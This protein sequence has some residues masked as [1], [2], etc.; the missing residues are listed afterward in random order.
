MWLFPY[1]AYLDT[2]KSNISIAAS[3]WETVTG[4]RRY[5]D[6]VFLII[7]S[8]C[9]IINITVLN[10][11]AAS[12]IRKSFFLLGTFITLTSVTSLSVIGSP[13][14]YHRYMLRDEI[15]V[16]CLSVL[17]AWYAWY[18]KRQRAHDFYE[19]KVTSIL[20]HPIPYLF[21]VTSVSDINDH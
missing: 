21:Y 10:N 11:V 17:Y 12:E 1:V 19:H 8:I 4:R 15:A 9:Y 7:S 20:L 5:I 6:L 2:V 18:G 14:P 3:T 16:S 13:S